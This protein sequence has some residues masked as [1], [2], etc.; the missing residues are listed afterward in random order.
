MVAAFW[1][2]IPV[3]VTQ[4]AGVVLHCHQD[5]LLVTTHDTQ[6]NGVVGVFYPRPQVIKHTTLDL[7]RCG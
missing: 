3:E 6:G 5:T 4:E 1:A 2:G 7:K